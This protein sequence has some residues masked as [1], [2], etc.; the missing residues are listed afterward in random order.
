M[1]TSYIL[2]GWDFFAYSGTR[3]VASEPFFKSHPRLCSAIIPLM[4]R[5]Q[6]LWGY[7]QLGPPKSVSFAQDRV[8][9]WLDL[10]CALYSLRSFQG[11][12]C[13]CFRERSLQRVDLSNFVLSAETEILPSHSEKWEKWEARNVSDLHSFVVVVVCVEYC[14]SGGPKGTSHI[15]TEVI[16]FCF[17]FPFLFSMQHFPLNS[18][19]DPKWRQC[20]GP[21]FSCVATVV[22]FEL[23]QS[24]CY[25]ASVDECDGCNLLEPS[26]PGCCNTT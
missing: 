5:G 20:S 26:I 25:L 23:W 13:H 10:V 9:G 12:S 7:W 14:F 19:T 22:C 8:I 18:V 21:I 1:N 2:K 3:V 4:S 6:L 11:T 16:N 24:R 15:P 17:D